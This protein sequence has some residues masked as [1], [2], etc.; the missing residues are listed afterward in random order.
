M[1]R[2]ARGS[3]L[4]AGALAFSLAG[5]WPRRSSHSRRPRRPGRVAKVT[6]PFTGPV[7]PHGFGADAVGT[8]RV[9]DT[10][11]NLVAWLARSR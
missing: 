1:R 3:A 11:S 2:Y 10:G 5:C 4:A 9:L 8:V 6:L 7:F